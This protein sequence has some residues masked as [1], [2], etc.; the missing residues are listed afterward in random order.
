MSLPSAA[1]LL[2]GVLILKGSVGA[3]GNNLPGDVRLVQMLLNDARVASGQSPI[4]VDGLAGPQTVGAIEAYQRRA[5]GVVDG[6][7]DPDGPT[8]RK[9]ATAQI[10]RFFGMMVP[11]TF[12][13]AISS[14]DIAASQ[15]LAAAQAQIGA[16]LTRYF[17]LLRGEAQAMKGP[18][19]A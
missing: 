7:C 6:R 18:S 11:G 1:T 17:A 3:G 14:N 4:T 12:G 19:V 13:G 8:I 2:N 16:E 5:T 15:A 9:L 10:D